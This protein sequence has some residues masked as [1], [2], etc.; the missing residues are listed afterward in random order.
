M[1]LFFSSPLHPLS[2]LCPDAWSLWVLQLKGLC[3]CHHVKAVDVK[4]PWVCQG[5]GIPSL[6]IRRSQR[7]EASVDWRDAP[8]AF[9]KP[10]TKTFI[11]ILNKGLAVTETC[12]F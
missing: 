8:S 11:N 7:R 9:L 12:N 6:L 2:C 4:L 10:C 3:R 5:N 1:H